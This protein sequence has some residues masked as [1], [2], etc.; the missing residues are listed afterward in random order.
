MGG[1]HFIHNNQDQVC[2]LV[3]CQQFT[4]HITAGLVIFKNPSM[5][6]INNSNLKLAGAIA[7]HNTLAHATDLHEPTCLILCDNTPTAVWQ[8]KGSMSS[9]NSGG[10]PPLGAS[11]P[12]TLLLLCCSSG[13]HT[14]RHQH[15]GQ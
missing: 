9:V 12:S 2:P 8:Q 5:G 1:V 13:P 3:W 7:H 4:A 11:P 6:S 14:W 10:L 15:H